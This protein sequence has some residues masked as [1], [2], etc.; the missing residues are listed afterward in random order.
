MASKRRLRRQRCDAKRRYDSRDDAARAA[1]GTGNGC[2]P[3]GC[4]F[5][6]G[7]HVGHPIGHYVRTW[8]FN[9]RKPNRGRVPHALR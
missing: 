8:K 1:A 7:W 9:G 6:G 4:A 3:Y 2:E 5:C